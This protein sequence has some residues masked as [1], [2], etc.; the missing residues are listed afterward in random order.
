MKKLA[1]ISLSFIVIISFVFVVEYKN[2][3]VKDISS[4]TAVSESIE[5]DTLPSEHN[6]IKYEGKDIQLLGTYQISTVNFNTE[7]VLLTDN[8]GKNVTFSITIT[9]KKKNLFCIP[10]ILYSPRELKIADTIG[11]AKKAN[12]YFAYKPTK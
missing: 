6:L 10:S 4:Q 1:L 9:D 12:Q 2:L 5:I 3:T 7:N 11:L 8:D